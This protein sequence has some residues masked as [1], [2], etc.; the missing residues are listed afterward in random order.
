MAKLDIKLNYKL[1]E[2]ELKR[3]EFLARKD[4]HGNTQTW[5][6][7]SINVMKSCEK[8]GETVGISK[9]AGLTGLFHDYGKLN[10]AWQ[11]YMNDLSS[12][13]KMDHATW[14]AKFLCDRYYFTTRSDNLY[15]SCR[16]FVIESI[17]NVICGHHS[18]L[19]DFINLDGESPL[20]KRLLKDEVQNT[21][22]FI[23]SFEKEMMPLN[24]LD[25]YVHEATL[26]Y[27]KICKRI[28]NK[29]PNGSD[30]IKACFSPLF[31]H[32][33]YSILVD[34]DRS[35]AREWQEG[36]G[37]PLPAL[38][39]S[40]FIQVIENR[41]DEYM[42]ELNKNASPSKINSLR[43]SI[44]EECWKAGRF[45][46]GVY[47]LAT[48]VGAGKTIASLRFAIEHAK[49]H[50]KERI[51]YVLP[52]TAIIEQ[53]AE[54]V[55]QIL[56]AEDW[57]LEH[58]GQVIF[59]DESSNSSYS[60][61]I[62]KDNWDAPVI[63]TTMYQYL[64]AFY[65]G[66]GKYLRRL[67]HLTNS[68]V[69]FDEVQSVPTESI[70]MFNESVNYLSEVGNTTVLL[71]TA[72]QPTL[73]QVTHHIRNEIE[74]IV[75]NESDL[76]DAF[77]RVEIEVVK[78]PMNTK[79]LTEFVLDKTNVS[80]SILIILNTKQVVRNLYQS[81]LNQ[82]LNIPIYHLSTNMCPKHRTHVL[83]Q[84]K[85]H[86]KR[87]EKV[88][89]V[90]T[91]L[92]EAGV[93]ISFQEVVR[94]L[95]GLDSIAQA[96]GRCNRHG[97]LQIGRMYLI[98][99]IEEKLDMLPT[100][101]KGKKVTKDMLRLLQIGKSNWK[102]DMISP[103]AMKFYYQ[104]YFGEINNQMNYPLE[105]EERRIVCLYDLLFSNRKSRSAYSP[106][107][108]KS[109]I[110]QHTPFTNHLY[111]SHYPF[112]M[113]SSHR[114]VFE[115]YKVYG[116][117]QVSVVV[118]YQMGNT[119]IKDIE[120]SHLKKDWQ[121]N[122]QPYTIN[123]FEEKVKKLVNSGIVSRIEVKKEQFVYVLNGNYDSNTGFSDD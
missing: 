96:S 81:L 10:P 98:D 25:E 60:M 49:K 121:R 3:V 69:I 111:Q 91:P 48:P 114:T 43:Q 11:N 74:P 27:V 51:I 26:E 61:S 62:A 12:K 41:L 79:V 9:I 78:S 7:H 16:K 28:S 31:I 59:D 37:N 14:G 52:F 118:P 44:S 35:D 115:H 99:H 109:Q 30:K 113:D 84:V 42:K 101:Q 47:R 103:E 117:E 4:E 73:N 38:T 1:I 58:H 15:Q 21:S 106:P 110:P 89:C 39:K 90:S 68:I 102:G 18:R 77:K 66:S 88:I 95:T 94:S 105:T 65:G 93:N 97:E 17:A 75:T 85:E 53:N 54:E 67:H 34:S 33:L 64:M 107:T 40:N 19:A 71:C 46:P 92:I 6:E 45:V 56:R 86:L 82:K 70:S 76:A 57:L 122:I 13:E 112:L 119:W 123:I 83:N 55:R 87:E 36:K 8:Y 63:F 108:N 120:T 32:H 72:T 23:S 104:R 116:G 22:Q 24:K 80:D 5:K 29:Y 2:K 100:V 50:K 20:F